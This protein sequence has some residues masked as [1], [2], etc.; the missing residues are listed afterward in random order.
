MRF[1]TLSAA[2][3]A[4]SFT[5]STTRLIT[6][7]LRG[8]GLGAG[9]GAGFGAGRF[10]AALLAGAFLAGAFFAAA[11]LAGARRFAALFFPPA[12]RAEVFFAAFFVAFLEDLPEDFFFGDFLAAM[13]FLLL[14][15]FEWGSVAIALHDGI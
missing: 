11:F 9:R 6:V 4:V 7:G 15:R 8:R 13:R 2:V 10:A 12:R 14:K 1:D 5:V 3:E